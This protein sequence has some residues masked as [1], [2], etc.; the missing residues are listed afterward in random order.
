[1]KTLFLI[2]SIL[3][4]FSQVP[5]A[6]W[7]I[8]RYNKVKPEWLALVQ[9]IVFCA[10]ISVGI[11]AFVLVEKHYY[12]LAGAVVEIV[13]NIYYYSNQFKNI[14]DPIKKHWLAYFLAVLIPITIFVFSYQ[15]A[16]L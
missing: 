8:E 9:N 4:I 2:L 15:Y 1:M 5:H 16:K 12:A 13:I 6:F 14:Q 11:M 7:S 3:A 10:I